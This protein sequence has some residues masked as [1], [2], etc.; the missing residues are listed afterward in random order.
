MEKI[1]VQLLAMT[2]T[3]DTQAPSAHSLGLEHAAPAVFL[4]A[5]ATQAPHASAG[6]GSATGAGLPR[7][8]AQAVALV[9][10]WHCPHQLERHLFCEQLASKHSHTPL[11]HWGAAVQVSPGARVATQAFPAQKVPGAAHWSVPSFEQ[12][13]KQLEVLA[14]QA[15]PLPQAA[16]V[17]QQVAFASQQTLF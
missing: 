1:D 15:R 5:P 12:V 10:Y 14:S 11:A 7:P 8:A 16:E 13:A 3:F 9:A 2:Q 6:F 17:L 4:H